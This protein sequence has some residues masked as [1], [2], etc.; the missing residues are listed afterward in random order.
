M[1]DTCIVP[2]FYSFLQFIQTNSW[3]F[4]F[5]KLNLNLLV[6]FFS[7]WSDRALSYVLGRYLVEW[8][9]DQQSTFQ[10]KLHATDSSKIAPFIT[11]LSTLTVNATLWSL[12]FDCMQCFCILNQIFQIWIYRQLRRLPLFNSSVF[13]SYEMLRTRPFQMF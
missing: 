4:K 10:R 11:L 1:F 9:C 12:A 7:W 3:V 5:R 8:N 6:L 2:C 13:S